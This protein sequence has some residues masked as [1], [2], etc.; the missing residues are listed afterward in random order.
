MD[1][2]SEDV[3]IVIK[4]FAKAIKKFGV[5]KVIAAID[6]LNTKG[7]IGES[8]KNLVA[9]TINQV[10]ISFQVNP[11]DLKRKNIRGVIID[12]R[13][14]CFILLKKYLDLKHE[15]IAGLFGSRNHSLVSNALR[16]FNNLDYNIKADRKFLDIFREVEKKVEEKKDILWLKHS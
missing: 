15:D 5:K 16:E 8:H 11:D 14:M 13:S 4:Q 7:T 10:S 3:S 12:A 9:Y 2:K 1:D 6:E